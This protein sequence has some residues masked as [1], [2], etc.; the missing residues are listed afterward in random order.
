MYGFSSNPKKQ[1]TDA[2]SK[3]M[4]VISEGEAAGAT[5]CEAGWY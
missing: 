5:S 3:G 2:N 1:F 4:G